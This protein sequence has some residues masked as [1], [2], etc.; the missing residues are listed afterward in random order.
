SMTLDANLTVSSGS[1]PFSTTWHGD[2]FLKDNASVSGNFEVSGNAS[3]S[4]TYGSGLTTCT[5]SNSKLTWSSATGKFICAT[6]SEGLAGSIG[7]REG[8]SGTFT[9]R[10]SISFNGAHFTVNQNSLTEASISLD[11]GLGG[12]ASLSQDEIVTGNWVNTTNP[13]ADNEVTDTL[14]LTNITGPTSLSGNFELPSG[15]ASA[16]QYFGATLADCDSNGSQLLWSDSGLFSC[17]TLNDDDIPDTIT[18]TGYLDSDIPIVTIGNTA[19][20]AFER[21]LAVKSPLTLTDG[22]ANSTITFGLSSDSLD[23]DEFVDSMTLDANL[24]IASTSNNYT[25]DFNDTRV[26]IADTTF[27]SNGNVGIGTTGPLEK[28]HVA[29]SNIVVNDGYGIA[30]NFN[31]IDATRQMFYTKG[32]GYGT[33]AIRPTDN[34]V[35]NGVQFETYGGAVSLFSDATSGNVGIGA[36]GPQEK[37]EVG[38]NILASSSASALLQLIANDESDANFSLK[39]TGTS[40]SIA[41]FS[42]LGSGSTEF[43]TVASSGN[44]GI[45]TTNP[46]T[47]LD[48]RGTASASVFQGPLGTASLPTFTFSNDSNTGIF[49]PT[50]DQLGFST[51]GTQRFLITSTGVSSSVDF[52]V[53]GGFASIS[54]ELNVKGGLEVAKGAATDVAYSRFGIDATSH[55]GSITAS[56]DLL[57]SGD[58]EVNGS[59]AFDGFV[60]LTNGASIQTNFE[61][62]GN[63]RLGINAGGSTDTTVEVGG[64]ASISGTLTVGGFSQTNS[65]VSNN[66]EI[67]G[68]ASASFFYAKPGTAASPSFSFNTDQETGMFRPIV[69][70]LGFSTLG[71]ERLRIDANGNLGIGTSTLTEA[72][73][74]VGNASI[75]GDMQING[76]DILSSTAEIALSISSDDISVVGCLNVGSATECTSQGNIVASGVLDINSGGTSDIAGTLNLSGD[77]LTATTDLTLNPTSGHV[78]LT[79][80]DTLAIG[81]VAGQNYNIISDAGL[82]NRGLISD[83][84]L[85][86]EGNLEVD[87]D[88]WIDSNASVSGNFEVS[89]NASASVFYAK[90]GSAALP[91]FTYAIDP[92]TGEFSPGAN[93]LGFSTGASERM[94]IDESGRV[95]INTVSPDS[96]LEV[97][98]ASAKL[99]IRSTTSTA[100]ASL[101]FQPAGGAS[102]SNQGLF[103]IRAGGSPSTGGERLEIL[104]GAATPLSLVTIASSG[105][106]GIGTT[107]PGAKLDIVGNEH[108]SGDIQ[109]TSTG[110]SHTISVAD[111]T[112][113][114]EG[115]RINIIA[116]KDGGPTGTDGGYLELS[117]GAGCCDAS[118]GGVVYVHGGDGPFGAGTVFIYGGQIIGAGGGGGGNVIIGFTEFVGN[119]GV[120]RGLVSIGTTTPNSGSELTVASASSDISIKST[121]ATASSSLTFLPGPSEGKFIIRAGGSPSTGG[122]RLEILN[123]AATPLSLVTIASSGNVGIGTTSPGT[124]LDIIGGASVSTNFEVTGGYASISNTLYVQQKGNVGIG[125]TVPAT[126][127]DVIGAASVSGNFEVGT[128]LYRFT[129]TGASLSEPFEFTDYASASKYFGA[130]FGSTGDCNDSTEALGWD[131]GTGLFNCR[132]LAVADTS[133]T[134]GIGIDISTNDFTFDATELE[135]LNWGAGGNA[136][137]IWTFN[138]SA[139]DPTLTW[140][141]SGATLSLNFEA[142]GY[143]SASAFYAQS[144]TAL[145]PSFTFNNDPN[146]GIF[147][148]AADQLGFSTGGTQRFLITST[149]VSSSV[150]FEVTSGFASISG[151]LNVKGGLEV[152]KGAATDVAYSRFGIDATSHAGSI[153][154]SNDLLISGDL[155]VNGSTAFDGFVLIN[156]PVAGG[157][158]LT[159]THAR[160]E[161]DLYILNGRDSNQGVGIASK[162]IG[163]NIQASLGTLNE[164]YVKSNTGGIT[165]AGAIYLGAD[166]VNQGIFGVLGAPNSSAPDTE[167]SPYFTV[168]A[169]GNVG[170]GATGPQEK[171]E[172]GGN[173]L[174]SASGNVDLTLNNTQQ[175]YGKFILRSMASTAAGRLDIIGGAAGATTLVSIASSGNFGLGTTNLA[176]TFTITNATPTLRIEDT[177]VTIPDYSSIFVSPP[178]S[179]TTIGQLTFSAAATGG[180]QLAGFTSSGANTGLPLILLGYH[181]GTAPTTGAVQ[182]YGFKHDG[183]TSRAALS[184]AEPILTILAGTS[185]KFRFTGAGNLGIGNTS[186]NALLDVSGNIIASSSASAL[187]QLVANNETDA[188]FSLKVTGTSG[189]IARFSILGSGSTEFFTVASSGNV[190]IGTTGPIAQL[191]IV[192]SSAGNALIVSGTGINYTF[193]DGLRIAGSDTGN[194]IYNAANNIG[195]TAGS[196]QDIFISLVSAQATGLTVKTATGNVG[197]GNTSPDAKLDV[198]GNIIASSSASAL[199]Q[200]VANNETDANFSLKVTGTSG[201]IARFSILGSGSTEFF[202]V[203]SSGNVGIGTTAPAYLLDTLKTSVVTS[204]TDIAGRIAMVADP[205]GTSTAN[206]IGFSAGAETVSSDNSNIAQLTGMEY[207]ADHRGTGTLTTAYGVFGTARK[208]SATTTSEVVG[209]FG[210]VLSSGSSGTITNARGILGKVSIGAG[211]TVAEAAAVFAAAPADTSSGR[212]TNSYGLFVENSANVGS[213][214]WAVYTEGTASSAFGG[215]V[216]IGTTIPGAELHV[217]DSSISTG[218]VLRLQ[219]SNSTCNLT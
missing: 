219:D 207:G 9:D 13:W 54:G 121:T 179:S 167:L 214:N 165:T 201:S 144:G 73:E 119:G 174:A 41:R 188:N 185:E 92:D 138:L 195:I 152:A 102:S 161:G 176:A 130:A 111:A 71:I 85:F 25:I 47:K 70:Q 217:Y 87:S 114:V 82:T 5:G 197:I 55:A 210:S 86:I 26:D 51:G 148:P 184:G 16:S 101:V 98:S 112:S 74:V 109:F 182:I 168:R 147:R 62:T 202:T 18:L 194:T 67:G 2:F 192:E 142:L 83:N 72:L 24:T 209:L 116:G 17:Q 153:T 22:G 81:G 61:V 19:S 59:T 136:T 44:V 133:A 162:V 50:A 46:L 40:G 78:L 170:I 180:T 106:V 95:G 159:I 84:D 205:P 128:N 143:A 28:L 196:G 204:G 191:N 96:I 123:G 23:F 129:S 49:S 120:A 65:S 146:T 206:Y 115:G 45:G 58:L 200:L 175:A 169:G 212:I 11:W 140:T 20:S 43:F 125:T 127:L 177:G 157:N 155:E 6:E 15:Y 31:S 110:L 33:T 104:N 39:V 29:G 4:Q 76:N 64:N 171:L 30:R 3:A 158:S 141:Q 187:L 216:G 68:F 199:L 36:T 56:N 211:S 208:L 186:P 131:S 35:G 113:G 90:R 10:S 14:T 12:P 38:G 156:N 135:A 8:Y 63:N 66:L 94:R 1:G 181:G 163:V 190:G 69:N 7:I 151:E 178:L 57:I 100:S 134:G 80:G 97:A 48:V 166:D 89:G 154:A 164:V 77:I 213:N 32:T 132:T 198:S 124:K 105:N 139:G 118:S 21:S 99:I 215:R 145:L 88:V 172:V 107:A 34:N 108:I 137:N 183:G 27:L 203:A 150:N 93:T 193:L 91:S 75:S 189:S 37:L 173:I 60:L 122:E 103:T 42:I 117:G 160:P 218:T 126:K 52:E 149:G 53:I 79:S